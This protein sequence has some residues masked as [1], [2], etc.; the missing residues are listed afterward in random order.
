MISSA[1]LFLYCF[2]VPATME[3]TMSRLRSL[4]LPMSTWTKSPPAPNIAAR[5]MRSATFALKIPFLLGRQLMFGDDPPIH[6]RSTTAMRR[7]DS[8]RCHA[9]CIPPLPPPSTIASKC[10]TASSR[11]HLASTT[12]TA[13][14]LPLS[15]IGSPVAAI[16]YTG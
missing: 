4:T 10:S 8:A 14:S 5:R 15:P 9:R 3:S 12:I 16:R 11:I 7:P 1:P 6:R 13:V 2:K